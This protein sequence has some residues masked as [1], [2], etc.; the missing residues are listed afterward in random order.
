MALPLTWVDRIFERMAVRYGREFLGRWRDMDLDAVK[1]DWAAE[2][3]GL[4]NAPASIIYGLSNMPTDKP[5]TVSQ[6]RAICIRGIP[7][8]EHLALPAPSADLKRMAAE[9]DRIRNTTPEGGTDMKAWAKKLKAR[10]E[11]GERL[12]PNQIR[13]YKNAL[14]LHPNGAQL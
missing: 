11:A 4:Q 8:P 13:C 9:F 1:Q 14:G 2:L 10:A 6:F 3:D 7:A 5:P 12:N